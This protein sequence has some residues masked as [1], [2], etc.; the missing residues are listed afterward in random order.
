MSSKRWR[1]RIAFGLLGV[2]LVGWA[3]VNYIR[4]YCC[5]PINL[6]LSGGNVCPLRS[7]MAKNICGEVRDAGITLECMSGTNSES[8]CAAVDK[9]DLDLG[10]VLGGCPPDAYPNVRQVA[11][12]GVD[13]LHLLVRPELV[14]GG[15]P[16]LERLRGRRVSLGET[17]SNGALLAESLMC[18]AGLK[19]AAPNQTGDFQAE[20]LKDRDLHLMLASIRRASPENRA[21]F[22]AILP[23]AVFLVDTMPAPIADEL[24]RVAGYQL[25]SLPYAQALHLDDRRDHGH[26]QGKLENNRLESV[27]IPAYAYG[28]N[29]P[30]PAADCETFGLRLLLVANKKTP[31][32]AVLRVL[33]ALDGEVAERYHINFDIANQTCEF[34]IHPGAE[35]FA[36]GRKPLMVGELI[37]PVSSFFSVAGA[38][39]A[40]ALG[41]W[42][43]L[44]GLKAVHPDV[45]LRQ[46]DRIERLLRGDEHD[47]AA[48]APPRD[49]V[50]YLEARLAIVKQTAIDDY[51]HHRITREEALVSILTMVADTR[52]LLVQRRRQID[53]EEDCVPVRPNR[54][55]DAA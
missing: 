48:P 51:S 21:S 16:V 23:D 39:A 54:L 9:G 3:G 6:R 7:R 50:D 36:K 1:L 12:F 15:G 41:I 2:L 4:V 25:V 30:V 26:A 31:A 33:R 24:V 35:A 53:R 43:F 49:L 5:A 13:P 29:P 44:R 18:F 45:H 28:I 14:S 11:A 27:T 42:G 20:H 46:I 52:Q 34:P 17:G 19:A 40:G 32:T 47:D 22:S 38:A 55:V 10:L 8:I 37:E